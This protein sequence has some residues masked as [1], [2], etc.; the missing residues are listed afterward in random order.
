MLEINGKQYRLCL[1]DTNI[2]SNLLK[3][4]KEWIECLHKS[5]NLSETIICYSIFSLSELWHKQNLFKEYLTIFSCLP[6]AIL[7]GHESIF[8]KEKENYNNPNP[9]NPI[10][11]APFAIHEP[12]M[13]PRERLEYVLKNSPFVGR[14]K[15][16]KNSQKKVLQRIVGLKKNFPPQNKKYTKKE[17]EYFCLTTGTTQ[18]G[19]RDK[20]FANRIIDNG[21]FI[22]LDRFPSV[23]TTS[24][25]V[26]YKFYPDKRNPEPSD[27]FDILISSLL[28]YVDFCVTEGNLTH[29]VRQIQKKHNFLLNV[30]CFNV[31]EIQK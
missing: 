26:F 9:I 20:E 23:K 4:P 16:W 7:D 17:V 3:S 1:I 5:F 31:K 24:Y 10:A 22:D 13:S 29:I 28:P 18:V 11:L 21:T 8:V 2:L 30:E 14:T 12:S 6:S 25:V 15:Y 27:I 19:L